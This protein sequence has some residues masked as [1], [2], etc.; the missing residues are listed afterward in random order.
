MWVVVFF[1]I[2]G[3]AAKDLCVLFGA[4]VERCFGE[5]LLR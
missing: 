5:L 2:G 3:C 1:A 4:E